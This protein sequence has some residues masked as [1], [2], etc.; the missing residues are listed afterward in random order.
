MKLLNIFFYLFLSFSSIGQTI[1]ELKKKVSA[2]V[3]ARNFDNAILNLN[4]A[5][6]I[7]PKDFSLLK[8]RAYCYEN[9]NMID[10][11]IKD[12]IEVLKYD[13]SGETHL[14]IGFE[15][16][17]LNKNK[18][19]R[20]YLKNALLL[21]P[22]DI[23]GIYNFGLSFQ[24]DNEFLEAIK[25]YDELLKIDNKHIPTLISKSRCLLLLGELDKSKVVVDR[26]FADNYFD[27]EMLMIRAEINQK[28][29]LLE[30]S[31]ND[32]S[33][34]IVLLPDDTDL[35]NRS[36]SILG[37]LGFQQEEE[38]IRKRIITLYKLNKVDSEMLSLEYGLLAIAQIGSSSFKDAKES[39][40]I[41]IDL[42]K[43]KSNLYFYRCITKVKLKD[44]EGACVDL[45]KAN[46]LNPEKANENNEYF[47]D[48]IE[49]GEFQKVCFS[50]P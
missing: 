1:Q 49:F 50:I 4:K 35:L 26:F 38:F 12:N 37:E 16:M 8:M 33:R 19:A 23:Q 18:E 32:Y 14:R 21:K 17:L 43:N 45:K 30:Q 3:Q 40:D 39:L 22:N 6:K 10:L 24:R 11:A 15:Y 48:D 25:I 20:V 47:D 36:A 27:P 46:E 34:A 13:Q 2:D 31:L 5:I 42:N 44:F 7:T 41:S 28:N 29:G 9:I